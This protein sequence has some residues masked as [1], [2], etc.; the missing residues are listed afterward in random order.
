MLAKD[1]ISEVVPALRTSDTGLQ[2]LN[3]M[4]VFRISHLPIVNHN[5][6]LGLISDN[7]IYDM[8]MAEEPIGNHMLT[9]QTNFVYEYEHIYQVISEIYKAKLTLAP[10]LKENKEYMGCITLKDLVDYFAKITA[11]DTPGGIIVVEMSSHDYSAAEITYILE[12]NDA[13]ILSMYV[14]SPENSM[15]LD[16]TIKTNKEDVSDIE[17]SFIRHDYTIKAVFSQESK[18]EEL[19]EERFDAFMRY[20]NI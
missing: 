3:L 2:A 13:K 9:L 15:R 8:N 20:L 1:L 10:V 5:E 12:A 16:V 4:E 7:D 6:F 17:Q 19:N 11:V 14:T 18:M